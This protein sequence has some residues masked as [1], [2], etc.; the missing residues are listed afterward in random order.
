MTPTAEQANWLLERMVL[1]R[2][3]EERL[4]WLV[5]TGVP[6]GAGTV[7]G[8]VAYGPYA[9]TLSPDGARVAVA[10]LVSRDIRFF[11]VEAGA[12]EDRDPIVLRGSAYFPTW[13]EDGATLWVPMQS[14]DGVVRVDVEEGELRSPRSRHAVP[15]ADGAEIAADRLIAGQDE[16]VAVV[17]H[18][19]QCRVMIRPAA[20]SGLAGGLVHEAPPPAL[21]EAHR[22]SEAGQTGADDVDRSRHQAKALRRMIHDSRARG[23]RIGRR[24]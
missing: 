5:E 10:S 9:A 22:R 1:I 2:E 11:D 20:S 17:D 13:S 6:V 18:H 23:T 19:A 24:G 21:G 7:F 4:K 12:F 16:V 8:S 15:R 3:F 14:P